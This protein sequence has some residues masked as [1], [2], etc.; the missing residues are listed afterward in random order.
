MIYVY[1]TDPRWNCAATEENI[2]ADSIVI[3]AL[4]KD[5]ISV[6]FDS[7]TKEDVVVKGQKYPYSAFSEES[8]INI[9][10]IVLLDGKMGFPTFVF[11][12]KDGEK[13]GTH[14]PVKDISEFMQILRYYSSGDYKIVPYEEWVKKP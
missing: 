5:F 14:F 10:T 2:L 1:N 7:E 12:D 13:I 3:K 8:G 6:K 9:Y 11:L 4:L